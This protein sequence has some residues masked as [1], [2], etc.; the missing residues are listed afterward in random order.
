MA[1][2]QRTLSGYKSKVHEQGEFENPN[3]GKP[4]LTEFDEYT[5]RLTAFPKVKTFQ[6]LKKING[7]EKAINVDKAII[8]FEEE[9]TKNE[10]VSLMRV[11]SLNFSEDDA[12]ESAI[13]RFFRKIGHPLVE[14]VEPNWDDYFVVGMR[15]LARVAVGKDD[16]KVPNGKYYLDVPTCRPLKGTVAPATTMPP[17]PAPEAS[18]LANAKFV[19]HGCANRADALQRLAD[20]NVNASVIT[21]FV[22]AS[23]AGLITYPI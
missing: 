19:C 1:E 22:K 13:I 6:Q 9:T 3:E 7:V 4:P 15:F 20:A 8:V 17:K 10:V 14:G 11:D 16:K 21:A 2:E 18:D 12:F 23:S 5:L